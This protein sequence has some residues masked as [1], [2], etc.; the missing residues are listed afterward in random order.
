MG[1]AP[2]AHKADHLALA[3][4]LFPVLED[5]QAINAGGEELGYAGER[6]SI[7]L[8]PSVGKGSKLN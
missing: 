4:A 8:Q 6:G 7:G 3:R 5:L 2:G 1:L